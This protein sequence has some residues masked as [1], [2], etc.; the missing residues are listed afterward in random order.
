MMTKA[1]LLANY[2]LKN[3][4]DLINPNVGDADT[5]G[6]PK[7]SIIHTMIAPSTSHG[8][9]MDMYKPHSVIIQKLLSRSGDPKRSAIQYRNILMVK[10][11]QHKDIK[12]VELNK[13][14][15]INHNSP[16]IVDYSALEQL[17]KY[18]K[19]TT[20]HYDTLKNNYR[21]MI[22]DIIGKELAFRHPYI[23]LPIPTNM[24]KLTEVINMIKLNPYRALKL[25]DDDNFFPHLEVIRYMY[26]KYRKDSVIHDIP[27]EV[28]HSLEI[29]L[30]STDKVTIYNLGKIL[31]LSSDV[32]LD[33]KGFTKMNPEAAIKAYV[34]FLTNVMMK[35]TTHAN[36]EDEEFDGVSHTDSEEDID[37][38]IEGTNKVKELQIEH[39]EDEKDIE[40]IGNES[41]TDVAEATLRAIESR[42]IGKEKDV[43]VI[44]EIVAENA[45]EIE[46]LKPTAEEVSV[47]PNIYNVE[48]LDETLVLDRNKKNETRY[49]EKVLDKH[50]NAQVMGISR[51]GFGIIEMN[52]TKIENLSNNKK[53]LSV[54]I[55]PPGGG[56]ANV[57]LNIPTPDKNG[58]MRVNGNTFRLRKTRLDRPIKKISQTTVTLFSYYGKIFVNRNKK[59]IYDVSKFIAKLLYKQ[60]SEVESRIN[61]YVAGENSVYGKKLPYQYTS[62]SRNTRSFIC[63]DIMFLFDY[64]SRESILHG[65]D[66]LEVIE[67]NGVLVGSLKKSYYIIDSND[68]LHRVDSNGTIKDTMT[69]LF[70]FLE[71]DAV[72]PEPIS[73]SVIGHDIPMVMMLAYYLGLERLMKKLGIKYQFITKRRR[74]T[75]DE[76]MIKFADGILVLPKNHKGVNFVI[77]GLLYYKKFLGT[78]NMSSLNTKD[79]IKDVLFAYNIDLAVIHEFDSLLGLFVDPITEQVLEHIK[80]PKT[81][82]GLLFRSIELLEDDNFVNPADL[83]TFTTKGYEIIAGMTYTVMVK[84]ARDHIRKLGR[85]RSTYKVDPYAV[86][87]L[88]TSDPTFVLVEDTNPIEHIKQHH[89]TTLSGLYG[90]SKESITNKDRVFDKSMVG[91][92]TMDSKDNA[93]I[94]VTT[95]LSSNPNI[96]NIYGIANSDSDELSA[97][98]VLSSSMLLAPK[99]MTDDEAPFR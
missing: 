44:T 82:L 26:E 86:Y 71:I 10:R 53:V 80:E 66:K 2:G 17:Y 61:L 58:V 83:T 62:I 21:T 30:Y 23:C 84:A 35:T 76:L 81:F 33:V 94:G 47:E 49:I 16:I 8:P 31:S 63:D 98:E 74:A 43:A 65:K 55:K 6:F 12:Y 9:Y 3:M 51:G 56:T 57:V 40:S 70:Q 75:I 67:K 24:P 4:G 69:T 85:V 77:S 13:V 5:F 11:E 79:G 1:K 41:P 78:M 22:K 39:E 91:T 97:A 20:T 68:V 59:A 90:R 60:T 42:G 96:D 18:P 45:K 32:V 93:D 87:K 46:E 89:E 92:L 88:L 36:I 29:V 52:E 50:I 73:M 15:M 19:K 95:Y 38:V 14:H 64:V 54:K 48:T 27:L 25:M 37:R 72:P 99:S 34:T 7:D 28:L